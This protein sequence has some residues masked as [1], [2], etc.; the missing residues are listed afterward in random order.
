MWSEKKVKMSERSK[1]NMM[2]QQGGHAAHD[3]CWPVFAALVGS[4]G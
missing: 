2:T 3:A 1:K 4:L